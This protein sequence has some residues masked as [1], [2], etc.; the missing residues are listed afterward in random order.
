MSVKGTPREDT[1]FVMD[2][3][4]LSK[5]I[6]EHVIQALDHK[7]LNIEVPFLQQLLPSTENMVIEIWKVL[8]PVIKAHGAELAKIILEET[9]NNFVEYFGGKEPF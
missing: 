3:K 8:E 5:L 7:N 1:G 9:E 2:L 6:K 4:L